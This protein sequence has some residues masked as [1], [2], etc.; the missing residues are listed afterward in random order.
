MSSHTQLC[1]AVNYSAPPQAVVP[2]VI[3][4]GTE[5][6]NYNQPSIITFLSCKCIF[7]SHIGGRQTQIRDIKHVITFE[8]VMCANCCFFFISAD[9]REH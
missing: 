3:T 4:S 9:K 5:T 6:T 7:S 8:E 2:S 1:R